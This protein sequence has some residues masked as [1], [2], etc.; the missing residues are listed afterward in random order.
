MS[1]VS[2]TRLRLRSWRYLPGFVPKAMRSARQASGAP[3]FLAGC[4]L[5]DRRLTFWTLTVW[6]DEAALRA[7]TLSG[8]H[9][10]TMP[11][12]ALWCDEA[13]LARWP[14]ADGT[15]PS[16]LEVD[17]RLRHEG[18]PSRVRHPSPNHADLSH[19]APVTFGILNLTPRSPAVGST[20]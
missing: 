6:R 20:A 13:A 11:D 16:W 4:V 10:A 1:V 17:A 3:G 7:Y 12:L 14:G 5:A 2:V 9:S 8:A 18:R 15:V 19:A